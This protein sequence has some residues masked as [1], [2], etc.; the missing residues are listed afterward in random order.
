[1]LRPVHRRRGPV[2]AHT[3]ALRQLP[4]QRAK[5]NQRLL[6]PHQRPRQRQLREPAQATPSTCCTLI[7]GLATFDA[8]TCLCAAFNASVFGASYA[9]NATNGV[10]LLLNN[11]GRNSTGYQC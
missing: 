7:A 6:Q 8:E 10:S 11:Y 4:R 2:P 3:A 5:L 9:L 1:M